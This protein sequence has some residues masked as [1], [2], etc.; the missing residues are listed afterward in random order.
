VGAAREVA[1][2][3]PTRAGGRRRPGGARTQGLRLGERGFGC[4]RRSA[5]G[6][7]GRARRRREVMAIAGGRAG[8]SAAAGETTGCGCAGRVCC[9]LFFFRF[10][11]FHFSNQLRW[12]LFVNTGNERGSC[13][14]RFGSIGRSLG[15]YLE[16]PPG[17]ILVLHRI[18]DSRWE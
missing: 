5:F 18:S 13:G 8:A 2:G 14:Y 7:G 16:V 10:L 6:S 9:S 12:H 15:S 11:L 4:G 3:A 17:L 1:G